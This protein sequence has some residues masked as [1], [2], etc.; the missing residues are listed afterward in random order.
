[1]KTIMQRIGKLKGVITSVKLNEE[2][3]TQIKYALEDVKIRIN[4]IIKD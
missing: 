2:K 1:M 4:R 3:I